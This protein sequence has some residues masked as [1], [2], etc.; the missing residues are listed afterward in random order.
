MLALNQHLPDD[1]CVRSARALPAGYQPRFAARSK[2]YRYRIL[3]DRVRDP[4]LRNRAWRVGWPIDKERLAREALSVRGTHDFAAFRS[5]HDARSDT[6]RTLTRVA[7]EAESDPRLLGIVIEGNAFLHNMVRI[8]VGTLMDV[9]RGNLDEGSIARAF[10]V[11][12][13][14]VAGMT[15]PAHGLMLEAIDVELPEQAGEPWPR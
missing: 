12:E 6:V 5:A 14:R 10:E 13:R 3:L 2:R 1:V 8:L 11:K 7:I 9:A 4:L 15:A